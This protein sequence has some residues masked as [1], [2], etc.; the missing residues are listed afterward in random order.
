MESVPDF[1]DID[2]EKAFSILRDDFD[3]TPYEEEVETIENKLS[4]E[5]LRS[6]RVFYSQ[7]S[8]AQTDVTR[9]YLTGIGAKVLDMSALLEQVL[10][11]PVEVLNPAA[12]AVPSD[13]ARGRVNHDA[14]DLTTAFGLALRGFL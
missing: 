6:V 5:I 14:Y 9:M 1:E 2:A 7:N 8:E 10:E 12:A 4:H 11:V 13:I 3:F